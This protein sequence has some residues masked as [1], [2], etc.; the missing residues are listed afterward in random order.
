MS[1]VPLEK[2]LVCASI[3]EVY[4]AKSQ[5]KRVFLLVSARLVIVS[6]TKLNTTTRTKADI[7]TA[8]MSS[9]RVNHLLVEYFIDPSM[10]NILQFFP[11]G[12]TAFV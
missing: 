11:I 5:R 6:A 1:I 12:Y 8:M 9:V 4:L 3:L 7:A 2:V 10:S